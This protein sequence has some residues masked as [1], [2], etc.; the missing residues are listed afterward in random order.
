MFVF[1]NTH[2]NIIGIYLI[3]FNAYGLYTCIMVCDDLINIR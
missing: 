2:I 1:S 3:L